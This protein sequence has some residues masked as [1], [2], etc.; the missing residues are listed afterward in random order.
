MEKGQKLH[1]GQAV[2]VQSPS[3][4]L[5]RYVVMGKAFLSDDHPLSEAHPGEVLYLLE[6]NGVE[7]IYP[8]SSLTP[9]P[10]EVWTSH[11]VPLT[12]L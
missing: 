2:K 8:E 10:V 7:M 4:F 1:S 11:F 3:R 9:L 5:G 12:D 6:R